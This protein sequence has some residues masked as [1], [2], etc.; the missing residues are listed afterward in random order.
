MEGRPKMRNDSAGYKSIE[1]GGVDP[2]DIGGL[3]L[4]PI[5]AAINYS[6]NSTI[7]R[8]LLDKVLRQMEHQNNFDP[9]TQV[10]DATVCLFVRRSTDA[11][12]NLLNE[13]QPVAE[14]LTNFGPLPDVTVKGL[15]KYLHNPLKGIGVNWLP[16]AILV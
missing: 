15:S 4:P 8:E 6:G 11:G 13:M 3:Y 1:R 10:S 2:A 9:F 7:D 16:F 12:G 5:G 14:A